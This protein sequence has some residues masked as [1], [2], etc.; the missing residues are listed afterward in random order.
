MPV[1]ADNY[2]VEIPHLV[3]NCSIDGYLLISAFVDETLEQVFGKF[4]TPV[5][6]VDAYSFSNKYDAGV[7]DNYTGAYQA[8]DYL[9]HHGHSLIALI[10]SHPNAYPSFSEHRRAYHQALL[11]NGLPEIY[12]DL[13]NVTDEGIASAQTL[14]KTKPYV[15]AIIGIN[16][17]MAIY[18]MRAAVILGKRVPE[19]LSVIGFDDIILAEYKNP[20]LTTMQVDKNAMGKMAKLLLSH[21]IEDPNGGI[22]IVMLKPKLVERESVSVKV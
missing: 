4:T 7:S 17:E 5:V 13:T 14:M 3:E 15:S 19:D 10:G 22:A 6:L 11:D 16:D 20:P 9:I 21:R 1:D 12:A 8:V 18:T 2:P